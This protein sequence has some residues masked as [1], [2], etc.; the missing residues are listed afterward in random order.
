MAPK[1]TVPLCA[2]NSLTTRTVLFPKRYVWSF[3]DLLLYHQVALFYFLHFCSR[4]VKYRA[5]TRY[6]P[7]KTQQV[8]LHADHVA[9][10]KRWVHYLILEQVADQAFQNA[11]LTRPSTLEGVKH[12]T[13]MK[14]RYVDYYM[15]YLEPADLYI[16]PNFTQ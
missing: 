9:Q 12:V 5:A 4:S 7:L 16:T 8:P 1:C 13:T 6:Q 11:N 2:R 10:S 14:P 3:C 15:M